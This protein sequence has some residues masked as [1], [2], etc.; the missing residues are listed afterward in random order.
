[1]TAGDGRVEL[2]F[3]LTTFI[4]SIALGNLTSYPGTYH[5]S[6]IWGQTSYYIV[7]YNGSTATRIGAAVFIV[8]IGRYY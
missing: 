3:P 5:V 8:A 4:Y 1:M 7:Y 6:L 2:S